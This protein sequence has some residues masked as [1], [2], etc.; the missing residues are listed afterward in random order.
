MGEPAPARA[1]GPVLQ[2]VTSSARR[3]AEVFATQLGAA[4]IARDWP[5]ETVALW[6]AT[7]SGG[8]AATLDLDALGHRRNDPRALG[9]LRVRTRSAAV[10]VGHGS[11]TLPFGTLATRSRPGR[12]GRDRVVPFVYRS[13]GDPAFWGSSR[14]RRARVGVALRRAAAVV[15]LWPDAAR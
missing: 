10:V 15:A 6:P 8:Q 5:V 14:S 12:R 2:V 13:I 1:R 9:A 4:L 7:G 11:S 3:G